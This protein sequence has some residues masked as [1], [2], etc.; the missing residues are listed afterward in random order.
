[1]AVVMHCMKY[2]WEWT[3]GGAPAP[4][5]ACVARQRYQRTAP[6]GASVSSG[7]LRYSLRTADPDGRMQTDKILKPKLHLLR[8][9]VDLFYNML[10]NKL[11]DKFATNHSAH[12]LV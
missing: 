6:D 10:Y 12:V 2:A 3:R 9:V 1:M 4:G 8:S 5:D 11:Y 7:L